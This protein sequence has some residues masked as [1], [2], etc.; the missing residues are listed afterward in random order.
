[1]TV[2]HKL[3][4]GI[5]FLDVM[6]LQATLAGLHPLA[7]LEMTFEEWCRALEAAKARRSSS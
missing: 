4:R 7:W 2:T 1:V 3:G 5:S 6:A